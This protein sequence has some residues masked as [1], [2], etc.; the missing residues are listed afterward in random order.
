MRSTTAHYEESVALEPWDYGGPEHVNRAPLVAI[1]DAEDVIVAAEDGLGEPFAPGRR[2]TSTDTPQITRVAL[3]VAGALLVHPPSEP[4]EALVRVRTLGCTDLEGDNA[5][6]RWLGQRPGSLLKYL[7][8]RRYSVVHSQHIAEALWGHGGFATS[9]TVR[10]CVHD[11]RQKVEAGRPDGC[12]Q[13]LVTRQSG[14]GLNH[15]VVV[16]A[17]DFAVH[18]RRGVAALGRGQKE[19]ATVHLR[20]A[21]SMYRGDFLSDE[22]QADWAH[23]E[24]ERLREHAEDALGALALIYMAA[25]NAA[26]A[27]VCLRRLT[28][29]R[30]YDVDAHRRLFAVLLRQ[31]RHS[32]AARHYLSFCA[33]LSRALSTSPGF[34]LADLG[35]RDGAPA[36][37]PVGSS[38]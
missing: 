28:E 12:P 6:G 4:E 34:T 8:C 31:G 23:H 36:L 2:L 35:P 14:Y 10:Q 27:T 25:D 29:M 9:G 16:D 33:R 11:L 18:V 32:H 1:V 20:Q 24:R 17:D 21:I 13:F 3:S 7:I 38:N 19:I 30:P 26:A 37:Q 22:P 15:S 5:C